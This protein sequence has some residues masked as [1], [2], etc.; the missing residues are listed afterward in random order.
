MQNFK[1]CL[2]SPAVIAYQ[3]ERLKAFTFLH[4]RKIDNDFIKCGCHSVQ[5]VLLIP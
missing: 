5:L 3:R 1:T 2:N 4:F